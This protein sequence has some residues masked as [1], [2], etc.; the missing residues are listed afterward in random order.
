V[1]INWGAVPDATEYEIHQLV[2]DSMQR[3]AT[4][5]STSYVVTGLDKYA[6]AWFAVSSKTSTFTGRRSIAVSVKPDS[7]PCTLALFNNDLRVD[8]ILEPNTARRFFSNAAQASRPVKIR[9]KNSGPV[10]VAGPIP[11]HYSYNQ[12]VVSET[13]NSSIAPG[14]S[15]TYTFS[16]P[17]A[18]DGN[19]YA[20][21]FKSWTTLPTDPNR[22]NDTA[23][24]P[25]SLIGNEPISSMPLIENF[26]SMPAAEF[27]VRSLGIEP[28]R[29]IDFNANSS[30]GR[31]RSFI[32]T[33]IALSGNRALTLDQRTYN[34]NSNTDSALLHFNLSDRLDQQLRFDFHYKNHGQ[35]FRPG[36]RIWIRGSENDNWIEAYD[37]NAN[38]PP[39]G[40]WKKAFI[41]LNE[42][43]ASAN[44]P[45]NFSATFQLCIGQEGLTSVNSVFPEGELDDG[46]TF[47]DLVLNRALNDIGVDQVLSPDLN[48]CGLSANTPVTIRL[49]NFHSAA[50]NNITAS[51]RINEGEIITET[52]ARLNPGETL[53]FTFS[54]RADFSAF[55][56]YAVSVWVHFPGDTYRSNDSLMGLP[57]QSSPVINQFPYHEG[58][59][60]NNGNYYTTGKNSS[61]EWG[62]PAKTIIRKA[63]NGARAWVTGL[64]N[65]YF[66]S[67]TSYLVSPCFNLT[68][69][70]Q[71]V[72]S[73]SH[74]YDIELDYDYTWVEYSTDG[75]NWVK[76]GNA[77]SGTNWYDNSTLNNWSISKTRWHVASIDLP[78]LTGNVRFRFVLSSDLGVTQEGV[79]IDD[80][81]IHE[82]AGIAVFPFVS[83]P[84]SRTVSGND[85]VS[86]S[87]NNG[88]TPGMMLAEINPRG[89][90]LGTVSVQYLPNL[91]GATRFSNNVLYLDRNYVIRSTNAPTAPVGLRLYF[92]DIESDSLINAS[93]CSGCL[94]PANAY[95]L[96]ISSFTATRPEAENDNL[97]DNLFGI[98]RF[99]NAAN[100]DIMPHGEGY[101]AEGSA[102]A[103]GE[104]WL[105]TSLLSAGNG[106][107]CPRSTFVYRVD[108]SLG[109]GFQWQV[110]TGSGY[111]D[112]S[113]D[114]NYS[115]TNSG[116]LLVTNLPTS[117]SGN[118][119]RC[120]VDGRPRN[121]EV[122]RFIQQWTGSSGTDWFNP[123]NWGCGSL[124]DAFTDV[125]IPAGLANYPIL[126]TSTA[127]RSLRM[128]GNVNVRISP[129]AVLQIRGQ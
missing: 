89:Q 3:I 74:L 45:Q 115:G 26:E 34:D 2:G 96:G 84:V 93:A 78:P 24:K 42:K 105:S 117:A 23:S 9:V 70:T 102:S 121:E 83:A 39:A 48:G 95:D 85:W 64:T 19:G 43:L 91:S 22:L 50:I 118:R 63:A 77:G 12:T 17:F 128:N 33:G 109:S 54:Q 87:Q 14:A 10:A 28:A 126:N 108:S 98:N 86:F 35:E 58:F 4:T 73:F 27:N 94:R 21:T 81:R 47:D 40:S 51:Y 111:V 76:L 124:P 99:I 127:I 101:Y 92:R 129:G 56:P 18:N 67:E 79:G 120:L 103:L 29:R 107:L 57:L 119:Y 20:Y 66:N 62:T 52:V 41:N 61:W 68:G 65:N 90:D 104:C 5:S 13:I 112:L 123:G 116:V 72:L 59:E 38:Q 69:L 80:I 8:S 114:E 25:V 75:K 30:R 60:N 53:D 88:T 55:G 32:N 15:I 97:S 16:T 11:V 106:N 71:P 46:Y 125:V 113:D 7:G 37:L 82:K 110:N 6:R 44:P 100:T 31:A 49:K 36:N 1:Q 122:L